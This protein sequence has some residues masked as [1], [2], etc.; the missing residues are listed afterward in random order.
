[1]PD[2]TAAIYIRVSTEEQTEGW[3][4]EAQRELCTRLALQRGWSV[5]KVYE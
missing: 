2:V 1:M 4:L 5:Y 3:S